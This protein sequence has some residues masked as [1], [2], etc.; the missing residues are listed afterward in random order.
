MTFCWLRTTINRAVLPPGSRS[1]TFL[2]H[3][4][5]RFE[6][7]THLTSLRT[8]P[9][10]IDPAT[11]S[12]GIRCMWD[13]EQHPTR[14]L[15]VADATG[16]NSRRR[17]TVRMPVLSTG[18]SRQPST[19][20]WAAVPAHGVA[21]SGPSLTGKEC[22]CGANAMCPNPVVRV[23]PIGQ[24]CGFDVNCNCVCTVNLPPT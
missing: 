13:S 7:C 23:C 20:P 2:S 16:A 15:F 3:R 17:L 1:F 11:L 24:S 18:L 10:F 8:G 19:R 4:L 5:G 9:F 6:P 21:S 14:F 12:F 22:T